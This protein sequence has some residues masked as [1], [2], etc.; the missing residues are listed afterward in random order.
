MTIGFRQVPI[1]PIKS[2]VIRYTYSRWRPRANHPLGPGQPGSPHTDIQVPGELVNTRPF[3]YHQDNNQHRD[4][5]EP[6]ELV[7]T[8]TFYQ[9]T[10]TWY[11]YF[12]KYM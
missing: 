7:H 5:Q 6:G 11:R 2:S 9:D 4:I 8:Q 12:D 3:R 10:R 1:F